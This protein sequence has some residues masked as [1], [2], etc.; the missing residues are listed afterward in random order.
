METTFA[1]GGCS[2]RDE[3]GFLIATNA[4]DE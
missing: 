1:N 4:D 3:E 2:A